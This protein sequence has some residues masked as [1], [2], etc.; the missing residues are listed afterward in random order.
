MMAT[1]PKTA[2]RFGGLLAGWRGL[3]RFWGAIVAVLGIGAAVLQTL[4]PSSGPQLRR[5]APANLA[6]RTDVHPAPPA[7]QDTRI[8]DALQTPVAPGRPGRYTPGPI[9]DPDPSLLEPYPGSPDRKL[10][11]ISF[12]GRTSMAVYAAPFDP[13]SVRPRVGILIGGIGMSEADSV[14][15]VKSLPGGVTLAISSYARSSDRLLALARM[16]EHEYLLSVP[17]EPQ[18]FPVNDPDDRHA[19]MTSLPP[20]DNLDRLRWVLSRISGYVGVT[21][22]LGPMRGE[23]LLGVRDQRDSVMEELALR[24]LLFV[25]ARTAEA[26]TGES[27]IT[28]VWSRSASLVIDDDP[29]DETTI[30]QRLELLSRMARDAG[31]ALGIVSLPRPR[32]L[33]RVV[34]WTNTLT[35]KGLALAPVSALVVPASAKEQDK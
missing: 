12:D 24:G 30:D 22:L 6:V 10:P 17:M 18:G 11:R 14:A 13:S 16:T 19:L 23:R 21:N 29:A 20:A 35:S 4:G 33:D 15:A 9:A 28:K 2:R 25:D 32:T 34:A 8:H 27:R 5:E 1:L 31:S 7:L 26:Q 3:G